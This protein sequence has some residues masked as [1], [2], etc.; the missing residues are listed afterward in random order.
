M[1][2]IPD[3]VFD[4]D[5]ALERQAAAPLELVLHRAAAPGD[6]PAE[7][8]QRATAVV[9]Y[10]RLV[11]DAALAARLAACRILVRA[12][13]GC[14]TVDLAAFAR[15]GIPVCNVPDYGVAEVADH[16]IALL[17]A[18]ARGIVAFHAGIAADP[19][20]GWNWRRWP[21]PVRRLAGQTLL[22]IGFGTIGRAVARRA[23]ALDLAVSYFDPLVPAAA[24]AALDARRCEDLDA[25]LGSADIVTLHAAL[26]PENRNL[27]DHRRLGLMKPGVLILNTA[28]GGLIDL[29]AL[30]EGLA[31]GR[32][33]GA[34]LD[35]LPA[36]PP[37]PAHPLFR[38]LKEQAPWLDGRL[39]VTP[40]AA[41]LSAEAIRDMRLKAVET[42]VDYL[43][44]GRLRHCV[45]AGLMAARG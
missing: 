17:L 45:N 36:E 28:R 26:T 31:A 43:R 21:A 38:A 3:A 11:Y 15:R 14:D 24:G 6:V 41:F 37:D 33:A 5:H 8:W 39:I 27:L 22:I 29:D 30:A 16:T 34:G 10:H 12:G 1:L 35:V 7:D 40:H 13:V 20:G 44:S 9:A 25:A 4:D 18:L 32:I 42:A 2:L 19:A 23:R